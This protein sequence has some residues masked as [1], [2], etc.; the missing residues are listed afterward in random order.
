MA[1]L[2][3]M[4]MVFFL[5]TLFLFS[6]T[7]L[8][9]KNVSFSVEGESTLVNI[10]K[11]DVNLIKFPVDDV[12]GYTKSKNIE[13]RVNGKNVV[14]SYTAET[15][16]MAAVLFTTPLG[17]YS[18]LLKPVD[19]PSETIIVQLPRMRP[20]AVEQDQDGEEQEEG[21]CRSGSSHT[22]TVKELMKAMYSGKELSGYFP[23]KV[24]QEVVSL[25]GLR[26]TVASAYKGLNIDGEK[27]KIVNISGK[28]ID[29]EE[30]DFHRKGILAVSLDKHSLEPNEE[31][32]LYLVVKRPQKSKP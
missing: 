13:L 16:E 11:K 9:V 5:A 15:D 6:G 14:I 24:N 23:Q 2:K 21:S 28:K 7:A 32:D 27:H 19:I 8:A 3:T 17:S 30:N 31:T 18:L 25:S 4:M 26:E 10:S 1:T 29:L 22:Q 12:K 20:V